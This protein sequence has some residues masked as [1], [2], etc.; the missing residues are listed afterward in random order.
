MLLLLFL[1]QQPRPKPPA[2]C[3]PA[4]VLVHGQQLLRLPRH[5]LVRGLGVG[6]LVTTERKITLSSN[7]LAIN[8]F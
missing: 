6:V 5:G 8:A 4:R 3:G 1:A 2:R 7:A